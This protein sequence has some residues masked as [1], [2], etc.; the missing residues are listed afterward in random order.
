MIFEP[1][2]SK[3]REWPTLPV[4]ISMVTNLI[5]AY[6]HTES[7]LDLT[8]KNKL[9]FLAKNQNTERFLIV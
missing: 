6:I 9:N 7:V 2:I 3:S 4:F 1:V 5:K 8:N